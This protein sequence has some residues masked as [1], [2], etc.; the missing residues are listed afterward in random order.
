[1]TRAEKL[2]KFLQSKGF[3]GATVE[4][5]SDGLF[6]FY[7][8]DSIERSS[9]TYRVFQLTVD[10]KAVVEH[11]TLRASFQEGKHCSSLHT[12]KIYTT[13]HLLDGVSYSDLD[14]IEKS[15][16]ESIPDT[17]RGIP[18]AYKNEYIDSETNRQ[19]VYSVPNTGYVLEEITD[20]WTYVWPDGQ[21]YDESTTHHIPKLYRARD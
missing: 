9:D 14:M 15:I 1:M 2:S 6:E 8:G 11:L 4:R 7:L 13:T 17:T 10:E 19:I 20:F 21:T 18:S 16:Y 3:K 12:E 5:C